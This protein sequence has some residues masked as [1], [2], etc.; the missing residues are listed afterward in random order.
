MDIVFVVPGIMGSELF[1]DDAKIWP[2]PIFRNVKDPE[3]LLDSNVVVGDIIRDVVVF[4]MYNQLLKPLHKWGYHEGK[5][6]KFGLV[7]PWPYNWVKGIPENAALLA[8]SIRQKQLEYPGS[9]VVLLAHS[10]GGLVC[11]YALECLNDASADYSWRDRVRLLVTFGTPFRGAPESLLNAFGLE[12]VLGIEADDCQALMA[13]PR[14]PSA[15]QL[16]PHLPSQSVWELSAPLHPVPDYSSIYPLGPPLGAANLTA[17]L[18]LQSALQQAIPNPA[19][20]KF[21]FCGTTYSTLWGASRGNGVIETFR[22]KAG[23]GT[24]PS[25]SG[26]QWD[27][28][29]F[30]PLGQK[31]STTFGSDDVLPVLHD[32]LAK[33]ITP[34]P[35][36][37]GPRY[38]FGRRPKPHRTRQPQV[39]ITRNAISSR[40]DTVEVEISAP[41]VGGVLNLSWIAVH[42]VRTMDDLAQAIPRLE[43]NAITAAQSIPLGEGHDYPAVIAIPRPQSVGEFALVA[44]AGER[45]ASLGELTTERMDLLWVFEDSG[46]DGERGTMAEPRAYGLAQQ[47]EALF[48][49]N[50]VDS[51]PETT[52]TLQAAED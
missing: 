2:P 34:P 21:N 6:G 11:T 44:W 30:A 7:V 24:V 29:Q 9:E 20:R 36:G 28:V 13:D 39:S 51:A 10:M 5:P 16:L 40:R 47:I 45:V 1:L 4:N 8:D 3:R 14:F 31:H 52:K 27:D 19:T 26:R 17:A 50:R 38:R 15:Y 32:L 23:D 18:A 46:R 12:G 37:G 33:N 35:P 48:G 25:W 41:P 22:S 49:Q 43:F 42:D